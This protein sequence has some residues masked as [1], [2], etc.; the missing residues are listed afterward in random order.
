MGVKA[1][2][3]LYFILLYFTLLYLICL[4]IFYGLKECILPY[5]SSAPSLPLSWDHETGHLIPPSS[6]VKNTW[7]YTS[8]SPH[9]FKAWNLIAQ[10]DR[11]LLNFTSIHRHLCMG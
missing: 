8:T 11:Y 3:Q 9:V 5:V 10:G 4:H 1:Q 6:Y 7:S 2:G